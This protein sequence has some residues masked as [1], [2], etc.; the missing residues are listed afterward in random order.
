M[1]ISKLWAVTSYFNPA[2][3][4]RRFENYLRFRD[5]LQVPL[6]VA[7]LSYTGEFVIP[8][9]AHTSVVRLV[10]KDVLWHK[11]ALLNIAVSRVP[12]AVQYTA[13]VDCD[14]IFERQNWAE[15]AVAQ[16][17]HNPI[18]QLF[19]NLHDTAADGMISVDTPCSGVA[20]AALAASGKLP[21]TAFRP[22]STIHMRQNLFGL[23]WAA[24]TH[25][26]REIRLYDFM[27]LGSGDRAFVCAAYGK[28]E[29]TISV[30]RLSEARASHYVK[31]G[32]RLFSRVRGEVGVLPG[33]L[34]HLWHGEISDRKYIERHEALAR[35]NLDPE[36]DFIRD[37]NGLLRWNNRRL[38][39]STMIENYFASRFEDGRPKN[40]DEGKS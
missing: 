4:K 21:G 32:E 9:D 1:Q 2:G 37:D 26:L 22:T 18:V 20:I 15:M 34:Y 11:E 23:A 6:V 35:Y 38:D 30:L 36:I 7:E 3:Y 25:L 12:D 19:T 24:P 14:I 17:Q 33:R 28:Y 29:E 5:A 16:L 27:I 10:A 8:E 39:C 40:R 31:W 13:W